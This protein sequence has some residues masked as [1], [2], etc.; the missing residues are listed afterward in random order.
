[1][2]VYS[3]MLVN[4]KT[5]KLTWTWGEYTRQT[6]TYVMHILLYNFFLISPILSKYWVQ[7]SVE[8]LSIAT[9]GSARHSL[10]TREP[11]PPEKKLFQTVNS[12]TSLVKW[13]RKLIIGR[14]SP[15]QNPDTPEDKTSQQ[16]ELT[17]AVTLGSSPR[18]F[19]LLILQSFF[20]TWYVFYS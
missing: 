14:S 4:W 10:W 8:S 20:F 15:A 3:D 9:V 17:Q 16:R 2:L 12:L 7:Y 13:R 1:M 6:I 11:C 18:L 19:K 5:W